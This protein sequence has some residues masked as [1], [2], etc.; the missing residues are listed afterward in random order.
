MAENLRRST[1]PVKPNKD[2]D[3]E[4]EE[5]VLDA[6]SG[7]QTHGANGS[8]TAIVENYSECFY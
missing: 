8:Q 5:E 6:L 4:Y 7:R 3:F 1:R 2:S